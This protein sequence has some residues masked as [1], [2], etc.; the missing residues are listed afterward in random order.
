MKDVVAFGFPDVVSRADVFIACA[1][2]DAF[3][4]ENLVGSGMFNLSCVCA[5]NTPNI[6]YF[7]V[8]LLFKL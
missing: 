4:V 8:K 2:S 6:I 5:L 7:I 1:V 3:R